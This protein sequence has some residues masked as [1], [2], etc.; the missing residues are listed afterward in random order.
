MKYALLCVAMIVS[1]CCT[2]PTK[3][4]EVVK[5]PVAIPCPVAIP[6]PPAFQFDKLKPTDTI[7]DKVKVLLS[8]RQLS[9][10]YELE[11]TAALAACK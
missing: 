6:T 4:P 11:L 1:G 9:I 3:P 8:D 5:V 2:N 10:A 7:W